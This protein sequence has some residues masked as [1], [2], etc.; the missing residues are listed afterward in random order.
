MSNS[1]VFAETKELQY[2]TEMSSSETDTAS[3]INEFESGELKYSSSTEISTA[4]ESDSDE[5]FLQDNLKSYDFEP[6]CPPSIEF[7]SDNDVDEE[8]TDGRKGNTNWCL[9]GHCQAMGTEAESL[10]CRDTN[11]IPDNY[12]EEKSCIT[13]SKNFKLVCLQKPVL[14]TALSELNH[15]K[16]YSIERLDN[17]SYRYAGYKQFI[18]WVYN[19]L[20]KGVRKVIPSCALIRKKYNSVDDKYVP[21]AESTL[22]RE[23]EEENQ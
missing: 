14:E 11:D 17:K 9:C 6:A 16:G 18:F 4:E 5:D 2:S 7:L 1:R 21:F 22:Y 20:G 12:F 10:C 8:I 13:E 19:Y 15:Y 23:E 3:D